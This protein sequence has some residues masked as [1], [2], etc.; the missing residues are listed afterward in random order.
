[1]APAVA[2]QQYV[3]IENQPL[4]KANIDFEKSFMKME[5]NLGF[6]R[7]SDGYPQT[8]WKHERIKLEMTIY[9]WAKLV[10]LNDSDTDGIIMA[11]DGWMNNE[12]S[13]CGVLIID[14]VKGYDGF[15]GNKWY[16]TCYICDLLTDECEI[17]FRLP[18]YTM[19][20]NE[21]NN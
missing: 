19:D 3:I 12:R 10:D 21:Y 5:G 11:M 2:R 1:M 15:A 9:P 4:M 16:I 13:C 17:S 6:I 14:N 8:A 18:V 20:T 7:A